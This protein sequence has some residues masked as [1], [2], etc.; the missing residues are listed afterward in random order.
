[1][2]ESLD[3]GTAATIVAS[4]GI[5]ALFGKG[6][7]WWAN[8]TKDRV[9]LLEARMDKVDRSLTA[10]TRQV[11]CLAG[12]CVVLVNEIETHIPH[13][14]A[15]Q[16]ARIMV[17]AEFPELYR[18]IFRVDPNIPPDMSAMLHTIDAQE[19]QHDWTA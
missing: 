5:L 15:I 7:G 3:T 8:K 9:T 17:G 18:R 10:S 16:Q 13:S 1:M 11:D 4:G 6:I 19:T 14:R 2:S 12:V